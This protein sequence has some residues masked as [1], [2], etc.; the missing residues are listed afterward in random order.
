MNSPTDQ[1]PSKSPRPWW[2]LHLLT[3]VL[4]LLV[5]GSLVVMNLMDLT[6]HQE[7]AWEYNPEPYL[8]IWSPHEFG[9]PFVYTQPNESITRFENIWFYLKANDDNWVW[10]WNYSEYLDFSLPYIFSN[11]LIAFAILIACIFTTETYLRHQSKWQ[12]T[13]QGIILLTVFIALLLA[14]AKYNLIRWQGDSAWEFIPFFF[15]ALG[16]WCVFWTGWRLV[17]A[18]VGRVGGGLKDG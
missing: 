6:F 8:V 17:A 3:W 11:I 9:W 1:P 14:N 7:E 13:I 16:L 5:G 4:V 18:G 15:I 10:L 2:K 12:F